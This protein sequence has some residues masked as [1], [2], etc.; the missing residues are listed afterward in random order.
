MHVG[1]RYTETFLMLLGGGLMGAT[2]AGGGSGLYR[3]AR[4]RGGCSCCRTCVG[5]TSRV[6]ARSGTLKAP[7]GALSAAPNDSSMMNVRVGA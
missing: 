1:C 3:C 7:Y 6:R 4:D 5:V 2:T